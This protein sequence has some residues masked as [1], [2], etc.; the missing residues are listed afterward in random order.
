M[1]RAGLA[2]SVISLLVTGLAALSI[3]GSLAGPARDPAVTYGFPGE[4]ACRGRRWAC[5]DHISV[6]GAGTTARSAEKKNNQAGRCAA[7]SAAAAG[8]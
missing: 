6:T 3:S 2:A 7:T 8:P 4:T 1:K 5:P